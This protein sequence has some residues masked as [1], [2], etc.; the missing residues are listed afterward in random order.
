[1]TVDFMAVCYRRDLRGLCYRGNWQERC[2]F[3][4]G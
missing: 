3:L 1:M 4:P 2:V